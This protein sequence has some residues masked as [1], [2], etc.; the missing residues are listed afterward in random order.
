MERARTGLRSRTD[1]GLL[2]NPRFS[3]NSA[4]EIF[5]VVGP[6]QDDRFV[7]VDVKGEQFLVFECDLKSRGKPVP[8]RRNSAAA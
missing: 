7:V 5:K 8:N 4:G 6:A 1:A 2:L 3:L